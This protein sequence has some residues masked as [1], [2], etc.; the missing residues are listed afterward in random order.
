MCLGK[1]WEALEMKTSS[2]KS[3]EVSSKKQLMLLKRPLTIEAEQVEQTSK[4]IAK[5]FTARSHNK[6]LFWYFLSDYVLSFSRC[7]T[8]KEKYFPSWF[9]SY[10][11]R[12]KN[13][14]RREDFPWNAN[15][16]LITHTREFYANKNTA[17]WLSRKT[18]DFRC[19]IFCVENFLSSLRHFS[20]VS[21]FVRMWKL[22]RSVSRKK[23][24]LNL[25][26]WKKVKT[27]Q[28][29]KLIIYFLFLKIK[30][31]RATQ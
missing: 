13:R 17:L 31:P 21:R 8:G 16:K 29:L 10:N 2:P 20:L 18:K 6:T 23:L 26:W 19:S 12:M 24:I 4:W 25:F 3:S 28:L 14:I 9:I 15:I 27:F 11:M 30:S 1:L 5:L 22:F 7:S